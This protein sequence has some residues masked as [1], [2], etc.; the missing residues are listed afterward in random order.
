MKKILTLLSVIALSSTSAVSAVA[1]TPAQMDV[2]LGS[3]IIGTNINKANAKDLS[4]NPDTH[5][6]VSNFFTLGDSLSDNGGLVTIAQDELGVT[7]KITGEYKNGFSN[8]LRT[9]ELINNMIFDKEKESVDTFKAS[10]LIHSADIDYKKDESSTAEKVWGRNY[11]V[12]GATAADAG[13]LFGQLLM[14]NTG[15]YKQA[16]ALVQQQVINEKDLFVVEIGGN[17]LFGLAAAQDDYNAQRTIMTSAIDNIRNAL[18]TLVNNGAK[19]ILFL[20][21]PDILLTPGHK[22][23]DKVKVGNLCKEFDAKIAEVVK[24]V[25]AKYA[26]TL[27][28]YNLYQKLQEILDGFK[29][30]NPNANITDKF[31]ISTAFDLAELDLTNLEIKATRAEGNEEK[32]IDD[33]FFIDDVHPTAAGHKYVSKIIWDLLVAKNWV[34]N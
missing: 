14:K 13:G 21:P 27:E 34:T 7:P 18:F 4:V 6:G 23:D 33:Y 2:D 29:K 12:G 25:N 19:R 30:G 9:V 24:E 3:S 15:I 26:D 8:G 1:C 32:N 31:C 10:N 16:Q 17:D 11:S 20:T 28:V 22:G 5:H